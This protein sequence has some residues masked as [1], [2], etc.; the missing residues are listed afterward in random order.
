MCD[1]RNIPS[2]ETLAEVNKVSNG[3]EAVLVGA[4]FCS[5]TLQNIAN[6]GGMTDF[7][8]GIVNS[9]DYTSGVVVK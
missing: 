4:T 2:G 8:E 6:Q 5:G 9:A 3:V 7:L 1:R